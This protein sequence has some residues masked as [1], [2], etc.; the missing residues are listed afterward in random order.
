MK[1]GAYGSCSGSSVNLWRQV[2]IRIGETVSNYVID[3]YMVEAMSK[4]P[5]NGRFFSLFSSLTFYLD[6]LTTTAGGEC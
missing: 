1:C 5:G 2:S 4:A 3:T 6:Q